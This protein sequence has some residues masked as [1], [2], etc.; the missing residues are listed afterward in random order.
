MIDWT[1]YAY[2]QQGTPRQRAAYHILNRLAIFDILRDFS[3]ILAG[4]IPLDIDLPESDLDIICETYD[5]DVFATAVTQAFGA[6]A[7]FQMRHML[8][9]EL[10][11]VVANFHT[12]EFAIEIFGQPRPLKQQNAYRHMVIESRLL[13]IGGDEAKGLIRQLKESG[14]KTEPAFA[15]FFQLQGDPYKILLTLYHHSDKALKAYLKL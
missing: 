11:S 9:D 4:T 15:Q 3:P 5:P 2:L 6:H 7:D 1:N 13:E 12:G 8:I 14:L 10:P